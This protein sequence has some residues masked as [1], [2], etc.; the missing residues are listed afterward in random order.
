MPVRP[1][2]CASSARSTSWGAAEVTGECRYSVAVLRFRC[3][4][5]IALVGLMA[6]SSSGQALPTPATTTVAPPTASPTTAPSGGTIRPHSSSTVAKPTTTHAKP[7][8]TTATATTAV[9]STTT[10]PAT[11]TTAGGPPCALAL[12]VEQTG[13]NYP[14]ATPGDLRCAGDWASWS[15]SPD[16]PV[17]ND[18]YFAVAHRTGGRWVLGSLGTAMVCTGAGVPSELWPLLDCTE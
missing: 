1:M 5:V 2:R 15:G 9:H 12:I 10:R 7:R 4:L 11:S 6:C 13:T 14:G 16:D 3:V 17:V 8:P 18:G